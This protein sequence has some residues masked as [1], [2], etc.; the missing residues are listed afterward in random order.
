MHLLSKRGIFYIIYYMS[1]LIHVW[2]T[3]YGVNFH[4]K[5]QEGSQYVLF[6]WLSPHLKITTKFVKNIFRKSRINQFV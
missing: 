1:P 5:T 2:V 6:S 3:S 4:D